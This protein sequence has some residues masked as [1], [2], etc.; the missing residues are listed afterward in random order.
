MLRWVIDIEFFFGIDVR[1][2]DE[3]FNEA[4]DVILLQDQSFEKEFALLA[5]LKGKDAIIQT[6]G[7]V[8]EHILL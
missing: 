3:T 4:C 1:W 7:Y 6:F 5:K 2:V 8:T